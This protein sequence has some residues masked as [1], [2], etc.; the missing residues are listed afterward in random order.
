MLADAIVV[1]DLSSRAKLL[2]RGQLCV[3]SPGRL[4][5]RNST[6]SK[7]ALCFRFVGKISWG[8]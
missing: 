2:G 6:S 3:Y 7:R 4:A 1:F 8:R 5:R